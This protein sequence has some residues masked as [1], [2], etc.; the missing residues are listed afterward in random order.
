MT[1]KTTNATTKVVT[2]RPLTQPNPRRDH[3]KADSRRKI[4]EKSAQLSNL[5]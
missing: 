1:Q 5:G 4:L 2:T 3:A